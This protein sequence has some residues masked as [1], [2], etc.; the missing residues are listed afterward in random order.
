[1][2]IDSYVFYSYSKNTYL[3]PLKNTSVSTRNEGVFEPGFIKFGSVLF[4]IDHFQEGFDPC[5]DLTGILLP[6]IGF[7]L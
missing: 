3:L 1:L 2:F 6:V 5:F 7:N 4:L